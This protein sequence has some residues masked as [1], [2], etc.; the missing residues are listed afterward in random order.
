MKYIKLFE[1]FESI[2][3]SKTLGFIKS[4]KDSF[5]ED[6]RTISKKKDF[7][8]SRY[9]DEMFQYLPYTVSKYVDVN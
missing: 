4:G 3:L 5:L 2:K 7:P 6:I 9:S 8:F 1:S